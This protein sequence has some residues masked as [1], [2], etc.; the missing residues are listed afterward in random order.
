VEVLMTLKGSI[1]EIR[2]VADFL[3]GEKDGSPTRVVE[4]KSDN[5]KRKMS[6]WAKRKISLG[7]KKAWAKRTPEGRKAWVEVLKAGRVK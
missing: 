6:G 5:G 7:L 1:H 3:D 2:R 4:K